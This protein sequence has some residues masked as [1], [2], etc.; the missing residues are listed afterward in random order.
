MWNL[1]KPKPKSDVADVDDRLD[2]ED[3]EMLIRNFFLAYDTAKNDDD[4]DQYLFD[5]YSRELWSKYRE[6]EGET[7]YQYRR[8]THYIDRISLVDESKNSYQYR[9][10]FSFDYELNNRSGISKGYN[11]ITFNE[12]GLIID[13]QNFNHPIARPQ[14]DQAHQNNQGTSR[15][16]KV[17]LRTM[18]KRSGIVSHP[19][20]R[21]PIKHAVLSQ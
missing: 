11:L 7:P 17:A 2:N 14:I 15:K 18:S 12:E 21:I 4:F 5:Y 3:R 8:K 6:Q 13:R 9:V 20:T 1:Q 10:D 16:R 19:T